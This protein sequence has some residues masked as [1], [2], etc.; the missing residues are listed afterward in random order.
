VAGVSGTHGICEHS[1]ASVDDH[2]ALGALVEQ[3]REAR[4]TTALVAEGAVVAGGLS[5][6]PIADR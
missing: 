4:D 3:F 6:D 1:S 2:R 5:S